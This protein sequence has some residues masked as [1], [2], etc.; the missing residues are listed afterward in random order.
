MPNK[1]FPAPISSHSWTTTLSAGHSL[2]LNLIYR[3][4]RPLAWAPFFI[5]YLLGVGLGNAT[6]NPKAWLGCLTL[7]FG[8]ISGIAMNNY[9][10]R[11]L[12]KKARGKDYDLKRNPWAT[13]ELTLKHLLSL[14]IFATAIMGILSYI[15]SPI[16]LIL[17]SLSWCAGSICYSFPLYLKGKAPFDIICMPIATY[18]FPFLAGYWLNALTDPPIFQMLSIL[19]FG[20]DIF[21]ASEVWD[22]EADKEA[23]LKTTAVA[24]GKKS[25][26]VRLALKILQMPLTLAMILIFS[27]KWKVFSL[28]ILITSLIPSY[29]Y[30]KLQWISFVLL[31]A[32]ILILGAM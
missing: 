27:P 1:S 12:D 9:A 24:L 29:E 10:D 2:A 28:G 15:I 16:F 26:K 8:C 32:L 17:S 11:N 13:G 20:I 30:L 23:G 22:I 4:I 14:A 18:I 5:G 7:A 25:E 19:P 21:I 31:V 6:L 3:A